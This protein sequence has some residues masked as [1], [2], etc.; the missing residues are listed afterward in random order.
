MKR[1]SS[2]VII[3]K[4][5]KVLLMF[6]RKKQDDGTIRE[7]YVVPGGG[8]E[9]NETL[10]QN[11][12]RE[13]KEE[14]NIDIK[15]TNY[16]GC[17]ISEFGCANYFVGEIENGK[18]ELGGEEK[19]KNND[20]NLYMPMF[21]ELKNLKNIDVVGREYIL[22]AYNKEFTVLNNAILTDQG[23]CPTCYDRKFNNVLFGDNSKNIIYKDDNFEAFMCTNPRARG[24]IIISTIKHFKDMMEIDDC[25]C[26]KIFKLA[27]NIMKIVKGVY[28]CESVYLCTMCDGPNN[29]FHLQLIPRYSFEKRGSTN[30]VKERQSYV[31]EE[32]KIY[33]IRELIKNKIN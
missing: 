10:E 11:A 26:E 5:D 17:D 21:V 14:M 27:K 8:W 6:R 3:F 20:E 23:I 15:I 7:Y 28:C 29:H 32:E 19:T 33:K 18:V 9:N 13:L 31:Y 16:V 2:R 24:H 22:K 1:I 4:G 30:F 25:T 12:I